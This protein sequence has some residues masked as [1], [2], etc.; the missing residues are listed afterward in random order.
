MYQ[1]VQQWKTVRSAHNVFMRFVF[2]AEQRVTF[3]LYNIKWMVVITEMKS[4]Y[5][6]VRLRFVFKGL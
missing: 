1:Q 5:Y 4:A 2:I 3:V 6:A